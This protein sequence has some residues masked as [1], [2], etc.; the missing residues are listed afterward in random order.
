MYESPITIIRSQLQIECENEIMKAVARIGVN[1]DKEEL[2][3]ALQY[4]R[5]Q[6]EKGYADGRDKSKQWFF[7]DDILPDGGEPVLAYYERNAWPYGSDTAVR[8]KE[9]GI[10]W[11]VDGMWHVDGC[12]K[13]VGIAWMPIPE[14][15]EEA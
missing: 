6:Y 15:P 3:K 2:F 11:H 14:P 13:V 5:Q 10:G 4:D 12:S 1:V 8:K 7:V 9:I